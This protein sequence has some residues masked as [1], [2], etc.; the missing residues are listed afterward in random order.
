MRVRHIASQTDLKQALAVG[1]AAVKFAVAGDNAVMPVI[2]RSSDRPYRWRIDK[3]PL[4]RIANRE[5]KLPAKFVRRDGCGITE[6]ARRYLAPL[7]A[8]EA[9]SASLPRYVRL[10]CELAPRRLPSWKA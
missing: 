10:K 4:A 2:R 8:G 3:A 5:K 9:L 7:I 6:C 1:R